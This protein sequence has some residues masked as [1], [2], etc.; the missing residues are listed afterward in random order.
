MELQRMPLPVFLTM[1]CLVLAG[2]LHAQKSAGLPFFVFNNGVEDEHYNTPDKQ[3]QLLKSLGYDGMELNGSDGL[4]E[5]LL[6]LEKHGLHLYTI[7]L[8]IDLDNKEQPYE[9]D[10]K[11]VFAML[12]GK[13]TM[14]W[15]Y[16]TS[17]QY[18]PSSRE[19]DAIAVPI[20]QEI[21][22]LADEYGIRVMIYPHVN[23]WVD[24]VEDALR[25]ATKVN[26]PNLGITF[27][28]CHFLA[29]QGTH[30]ESAFIPWVEKAMPYVFAISLNGADKPTE[31]IMKDK[32][33]WKYFIQPLGQGNY[34]AYAYLTAFTERGFQGPVGLQCYDIR[35]DKAVHLK[36][37]IDA[38]RKFEKKMAEQ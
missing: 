20:L 9:K 10:L 16:I 33:P 18:K 21:A 22:D 36:K 6:A 2:H 27:N 14:P 12:K 38:W 26:R 31:D 11:E 24:N 4:A 3:V 34:D 8:N 32:N 30:A 5:T 29:D 17:R 37:S 7:Y 23:F 35:E 1:I 15:F 28:L 25:V 19:N 13:Q